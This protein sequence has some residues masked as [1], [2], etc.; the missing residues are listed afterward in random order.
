[1]P[2]LTA[3]A[4]PTTNPR[5]LAFVALRSIQRGAFAD[6]VLNRLL[7]QTSLLPADRRLL[8]EL[9]YGCTRQQRTLD[10]LIDQ[11]ARK[12][13]QQQPI[14]LRL[15]LHLGFYQ[16]RYLSHIP[17]SAAVN[18]TVNLA[19]ANQLGG[20]TGVINGILRQYLRLAAQTPEPLQLPDAP[21]QQL[22]KRYS[23]PDWLI[24][25][26]LERLGRDETEALCRWLNQPPTL[27]LR[28]N[29]LKTTVETVLAALQT[30]G[31]N[32]HRVAALPQSLRIQGPTGPI[33]AL[34]GFE[35]GWWSVQDSSAQLVSQLLDPQ[36]GQLV[37]DACAGVGGK[38]THLAELMGDCG[39]IWACD[40][41]A[42]RLKK[43]A[44]N[45]DRLGLKSIQS[46]KADSTRLEEFTEQADRVLV[47]A[48]CSSLGTL[49]RRADA[50]WRQTP[51]TI[52]ALPTL[53]T[54]LLEQAASWVKPG[55]S[56][57][58][59]TCTLNAAEND[60]VIRGF[61]IRHP[62]WQIAPV[63]SHFPPEIPLTA[64]GWVEIWP[65][66]CD[67]DGFFMARLQR[68]ETIRASTNEPIA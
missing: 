29:L 53:Q 23:Y 55:G 16:L 2:T 65:Q 68:S 21:I 34:P 67:M 8:T 27:D 25:L 52:A 17:P 44:A 28:V 61:L 14:D 39:N 58:Y 51:A 32:V 56:L 33:P 26:W 66:Q 19:K 50:R 7:T 49:H 35:A 54:D 20:L 1:M 5:Q 3:D 4:S 6:V 43:L 60:A 42:R 46:C 15:L 41:D 22:G 59:A 9:V 10:A 37:I 38:T 30:A 12:P 31:L 47:D 13:A 45:C 24:A 64:N 62:T 57:V 11:L 48:P 40:R 18:T 63:P 36:P